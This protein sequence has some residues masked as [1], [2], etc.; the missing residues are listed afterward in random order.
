MSRAGRGPPAARRPSSRRPAVSSSATLL[1]G[2]SS[3]SA[4][5]RWVSPPKTQSARLARWSRASWPSHPMTG[6]RWGCWRAP[7]GPPG[8]AGTRDGPGNAGCPRATRHP[9]KGRG[10]PSPGSRPV[11]PPLRRPGARTRARRRTRR[12]G[13]TPSRGPAPCSHRVRSRAGSRGRDLE[14]RDSAPATAPAAT[15]S[16]DARTD[17]TGGLCCQFHCRPSLFHDPDGLAPSDVL[18]A[19][20]T[21]Q[22]VEGLHKV[23]QHVVCTNHVHDQAGFPAHRCIGGVSA[24]L[25]EALRRR[26]TAPQRVGVPRLRRGGP[27]CRLDHA[28]AGGRRLVAGGGRRRGSQRD[29][30]RRSGRGGQSR[31]PPTV[32]DQPNAVTYMQRF[33]SSAAQMDT[34]GIEESLDGGFAL[35][36]FEHVVDSWLFP[37]LEA[38]G[39]G[40]A[41]GEI[42]VAGEHAASHAVHRRL[43]AAFDAAGSRS[44]GPT[45]V[46][47]LPAGSQHDLGAL[48]FATAIRRRGMD[49]L[50]LG[51][52]VPVS[53]WEA[54]VRSRE[55]RAAVLSV[56]TPEDRPAAVAVA[57]RLLSH[58][59]PLVCA[60]GASAANLAGGVQSWH[61]ASGKQPRSSTGSCTD[62]V[63]S[64][65]CRGR[66]RSAETGHRRGGGLPRPSSTLSPLP[67]S[68]AAR[69]SHRPSP[70]SCGAARNR[71]SSSRARPSGPGRCQGV[72]Q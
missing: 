53:S 16:I 3:R 36:S 30:P 13:P 72:G 42:D 49:V 23:C 10:R 19:D 50:Y 65:S 57:E 37:T 22:H 62:P 6:G 8:C 1:G 41:R 45:V 55:A 9:S 7:P 51:A 29:G 34:A 2:T 38:L 33:L 11:R 14:R 70:T 58:P 52:N 71:S 56:V 4:A 31:R 46:V 43:S 17:E 24:R 66:N 69:R 15:A 26:R 63:T 48:A 5:S 61:R 35:G 67:S 47:G 68:R 54:A 60:G 44:R 12:G 28:P 32:F 21:M 40:W 59:A 18:V 27:G 20:S 64:P 39:E 25:G